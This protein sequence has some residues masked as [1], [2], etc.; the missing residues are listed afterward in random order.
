M[1]LT[2]EALDIQNYIKDGFAQVC[3]PINAINDTWSYIDINSEVLYRSH[4]SW[5]YLIVVDRE[6]VKVGETGNRLG[7]PIARTG[8]G[9]GQPRKGSASRLGRYINGCGTDAYI[10]S[11]LF[12]E[13]NHRRV[14]IWAKECPIEYSIVK[15]QGYDRIVQQGLHK[16]LEYVIMQHMRESCV[17]P[18]LNKLMK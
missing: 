13:C 1:K 10:R 18:R 12:T 16:D 4:T 17:W 11:S 9:L 14:S 8:A 6:I 3:R 7:I 15:V 2:P 5:V